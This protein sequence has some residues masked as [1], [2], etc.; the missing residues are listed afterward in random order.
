MIRDTAEFARHWDKSL[1]RWFPQGAETPGT[2]L[3]QIAAER[4]HHWDGDD[5]GDVKLTER[6]SA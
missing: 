6:A 3:L 2:V 5:E 4:I 1:D